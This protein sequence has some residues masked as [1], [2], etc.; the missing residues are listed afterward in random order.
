MALFDR[1]DS[2]FPELD[3]AL[4][5][6]RIGD[7]VVCRLSE[8]DDFRLF[9]EAFAKQGVKDGRNVVYVRFAE[10]APLLGEMEGVTLTEIPPSKRFERFTVTLHEL[11]Q[12]MPEETYYIFDCLSDLQ[13]AWSTDLLIS[14]FFTLIGKLTTEKHA[15][16]YFPIMRAMHSFDCMADIRE[17]TSVFLD[18]FS[19]DKYIFIRPLKVWQ[20]DTPTMFL[21]HVYD[22]DVHT[23]EPVMSGV[24]ASR[25]YQIM[26]KSLAD[27]SESYQDFWD[28]F[29]QQN[30]L[31]YQNGIDITEATNRMCRI[32]ITR[33]ETLRPMVRENFTP[34]DY[35]Q[36]RSRMIGT[37][38]IGGKAAG[39]LMSRK[40]IENYEPEIFARLEPH[41]SFYVGNDVFYAYIIENGMWD[42]RVRQRSEEGYFSAAEE[43][44][45]ALMHGVFSPK[46]EEQFKR[47]LEY[48]GQDP[49]IVRSS[50]IL[51]DSFGNAFAGKYESVFCSNHGTMEERLAEFENAARI[52]YASTMS[53]A[54]LDYR[55]R[56]GLDERDEQMALLVQRVS[57]SRYG[58]HFLPSAAGVG[59]STSPY[60]FGASDGEENSGM[61]RLV[62]GLGTA[63]VDRNQGSYPRIVFC[64]DPKKK[65]SATAAESHQYSQQVI[66]AVNTK[67]GAI[68]G[69][70]ITWATNTLPEYQQRQ[71]LSHDY[72]A[73][74]MFLNRG[75]KRKVFYVSCDGIVNNEQLMNDFKTILRVLQEKYNYPV[76]I[77]FTINL[78]DEGDYRIGPLQC[79]PL[80]VTKD[81]KVVKVPEDPPERDIFLESVHSSM[82]MSRSKKVDL[83]VYV[84]P[85]GYYNMPYKEKF[86]VRTAINAVNWAYRGKGKCLVLMVP[87]RIC[88]SS[89]ELGVPTSFAD[90][91]EF[92]IIAEVAETRAGYMPELSYG[93]HIF[94]DLVEAGILYTAVFRNEKTLHYRPELLDGEP[95]CLPKF[96]PDAEALTD[97]VRVYDL[98]DTDCH[99][100]YDFLSEK[101]LGLIHEC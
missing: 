13:T 74:S 79:R 40:L 66:D 69:L 77:E 41:D 98:E 85:V 36:V 89:P 14:N 52:V 26:N 29:F 35:F 68:D 78:S 48:Y 17:R 10:H 83:L 93:S 75:Q 47:M 42:L 92:D 45:D 101:L 62:M 70:D 8:L 100:Y 21:P 12:S 67:T 64:N 63:A 7:N 55:K 44:A 97:I 38:L 57:G 86:K 54:A 20:R 56:R 5:Y 60:K 58:D 90:I 4:D 94:Q 15:I 81:S 46:I 50:S 84:D 31:L 27:S 9:A 65:I 2:G 33:D 1:V 34:E 16:A 99:I 76:D 96:Y 11:I 22:K 80:Q 71:L 51:E 30:E 32:M 91:S 72:D 95:N 19:D 3:E 87:G 43:M 88:T 59:Y 82:G 6:F 61:L 37:G 18:V 53:K 25:F 39:M 28:R 49:Y 73:E 23:F 24:V